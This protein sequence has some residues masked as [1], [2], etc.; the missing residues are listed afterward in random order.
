MLP[1]LN[2]GMGRALI[3]AMAAGRPVIASKVGGISAVIRHRETGLLVRAEHVQDLEEA[4]AEL[5]QRPEWRK[6]LGARA[7]ESIGERFST[8]SM[9]AAIE[10]TYETALHMTARSK[11]QY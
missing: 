10:A 7:S 4:L 3:E 11:R 1:S 2:E 8:T 9:V 6:E 5:L